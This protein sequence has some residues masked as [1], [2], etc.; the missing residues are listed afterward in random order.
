M[1]HGASESPDS[2]NG[3]PPGRSSWAGDVSPAQL[4]VHRQ[5]GDGSTSPCR[6]PTTSAN[7]ATRKVCELTMIEQDADTLRFHPMDMAQA[8]EPF[9]LLDEIRAQCPV[10]RQTHERF[11]PIVLV[12]S[13]EAVTDVYLRREEF[14]SLGHTI[15]P[16]PGK[17]IDPPAVIS[18]DGAPHRRVRRILVNALSPHLVEFHNQYIHDLATRVVAEI[19]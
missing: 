2:R 11:D 16:V 13:Y 6:R 18:L 9:A 10:S 4:E 15:A 1:T 12:T 19:P 14:I 3:K 5:T 17:S 8:A 7:E